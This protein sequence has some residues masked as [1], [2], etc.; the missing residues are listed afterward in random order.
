MHALLITTDGT[1]EVINLTEKGSKLATLQHYC[2]SGGN[3][4]VVRLTSQLDMWV[5]D[6][7]MYTS[8]INTTATRV[9]QRFG[10]CHQPYFGPVMLTGF[11]D[12]GDTTGLSIDQVRHLLD[13]ASTPSRNTSHPGKGTSE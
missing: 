7:G 11:T 3:V 8:D 9:A 10:R 13:L 5:D 6:E 4:D 1:A 12:N 2:A